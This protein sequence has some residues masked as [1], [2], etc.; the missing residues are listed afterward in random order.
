[1]A[2]ESLSD[3]REDLLRLAALG[4]PRELE[5]YLDQ[6]SG[7]EAARLI[8]LLARRE[9]NQVMTTLDPED[10]ADLIK[11][12]PDV[13]AAD[14]IEQLSPSDAAAILDELPSNEQADL[15][16]ALDPADAEAI[17]AEMSP[18]EASDARRL[19]SYS[20]TVAGGLMVTEFLAYADSFSVGDVI[21]DMGRSAEQIADYEVQYI[22]VVAAGGV[23]CG[24]LRLRDLLLTP[25]QRP[26]R[27]IMM[28]DPLAVTDDTDLERL[29]DLFDR[30]GFLAL[31][32]TDQ[33][34][35]LVGVVARHDVEEALGG[36]SEDDYLKSLGI[37][38]GE[39]LRSMPVH[40][41]AGRR[42]SW[43]SINIIL[44]IIAAS[45]IAFYQSTLAAV[46]A[47]AAFLP[48]ISDMSGCSG[49]QAVAVSMR[50][51]SLGLVKP[52][53]VLN[54]WL[55]EVLVG[56]INGLVLG[57]LLGLVGW[58]WQ[59]NPY[60]GLVVGG[61]MAVNTIIAVSL[62]GTLPLIM[63]RLG[64]DPALASGPILTTVT[65]MCGFFL[66]LSTASAFLPRLAAG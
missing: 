36:R 15:I 50:E 51:L 66:V 64:V 5:R 16:G 20:P 4:D 3:R 28:P 59:G 10:A 32:V 62:G 40:R 61:A 29:A 21:D 19:A 41:R 18:D 33:R 43:L 63:R 6:L 22:Y 49:N 35:R 14:L 2:D 17:L 58:L 57:G 9:Q 47:L 25:R 54:V 39:E 30:H 42:L 11:E 12:I 27:A 24:V 46:I 1:M 23:L 45:V 52:F 26:L 44:N 37:V 13:Q 31:P 34:G 7:S 55:K 48:I 56:L 8:S 65:D 60:L 53:E 38:G